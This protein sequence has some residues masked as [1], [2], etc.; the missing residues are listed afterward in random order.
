MDI[1]QQLWPDDNL[2]D[3]K[4]VEEACIKG[5]MPNTLRCTTIDQVALGCTGPGKAG[6]PLMQIW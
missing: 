4:N 1:Q 6:W 3:I 5:K 2:I